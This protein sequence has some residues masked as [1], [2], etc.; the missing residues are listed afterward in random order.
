MSDDSELS[1][2]SYLINSVRK[3]LLGEVTPDLRAATARLAGDGAWCRFIY[4]IPIT[5]DLDE[6]IDDIETE[7]I[8]DYSGLTPVTCTPVY[9][10]VP[11]QLALAE[12]EHWVFRRRES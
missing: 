11:V 3:A 12:G 6:L 1:S 9:V 7:I 4:D 5:P 10:P 2:V 8:A